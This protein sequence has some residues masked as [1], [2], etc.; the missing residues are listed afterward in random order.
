MKRNNTVLLCGG[1]GFIGRHVTQAL[2]RA[3]WQVRSASR[4]SVPALDYATMQQPADWR[5][6]LE[7]VE[8]VINAVGVLRDRA[9]QP[10]ARLHDAA[11]RAL[12]KACAAAGVRRVLHISALG[13]ERSSSR[14]AR[15][16]QAADRCLLDL[17]ATGQLDGVVLRPSLVF[18]PDGESSR[19][20]LRLARLPLLPLP[21]AAIRAQ[22]QPLAVW[23]L[24]DAVVALLGE[25]NRR[26]GLIELAGPQPLTLSDY[27][28]SLRA[29]SGYRHAARHWPLPAWLT[30]LSARLG[31]GL[32]FSPWCSDSLELL[33]Y[34]NSADSAALTALLG[35]AST[36]PEHFLRGL[37]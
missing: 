28:A 9:A 29:Q 32:P 15:S 11:P 33:K 23:D 21:E 18:G 10:M 14:Y 7:G 36:A 20:F 2:Q 24:A 16:K 3:G 30:R 26:R 31:D 25:Q 6:W 5:P 4:R 13:I 35:H 34:D 1:S 27:I 37:A 8:A 22:V 12:F 17:N 19:L